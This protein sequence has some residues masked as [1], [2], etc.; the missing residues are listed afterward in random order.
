[1]ARDR[2]PKKELEAVVEYA[3]QQ[4]WR[5]LAGKRHAKFKLLCKH[6][7]RDGCKVSVW[8]TPQDVDDHAKDV[9][10][11]IDRCPHE[12]SAGGGNDEEV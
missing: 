10:R 5:I 8:S 11:A 1:M 7:D 3:E 6:H 12:D 2:H 9:R 4:G